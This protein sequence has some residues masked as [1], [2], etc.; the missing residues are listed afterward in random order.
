[1]GVINID[2]PMILVVIDSIRPGMVF[3][4]TVGRR[5][6]S[7]R[8]ARMAA[9]ALLWLKSWHGRVRRGSWLVGTVDRQAIRRRCLLLVMD[10]IAH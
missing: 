4:S 2:G 3:A 7:Q 5:G 8:L 10:N 6:A 1:M 9:V